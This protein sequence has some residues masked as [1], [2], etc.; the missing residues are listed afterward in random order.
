M[1]PITLFMCSVND[2]IVITL[3]PNLLSVLF[4]VISASRCLFAYTVSFIPDDATLQVGESLNVFFDRL[5]KHDIDS[6]LLLVLQ[7][8][9]S[10][11]STYWLLKSFIVTTPFQRHYFYR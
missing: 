9:I 1:T 6:S 4:S 11:C 8:I 3:N 2:S 7:V 5:L 10:Y